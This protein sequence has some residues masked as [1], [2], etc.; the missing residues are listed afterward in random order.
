VK[1]VLSSFLKA[2]HG[3][4]SLDA[5]QGNISVKNAVDN[6]YLSNNDVRTLQ[7]PKQ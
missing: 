5:A 4:Q 1:L 7:A 3:S 2:F 6:S